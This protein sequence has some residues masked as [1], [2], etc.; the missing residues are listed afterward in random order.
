MTR[1]T[2]RSSTKKS[3]STCNK[4]KHTRNTHLGENHHQKIGKTVAKWKTRKN[5][6]KTRA[7]IL[8]RYFHEEKDKTP[9]NNKQT[10]VKQNKNGAVFA[11]KE[12]MKKRTHSLLE[13]EQFTFKA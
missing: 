2:L 9:K 5:S 13:E 3:T 1:H 7:K 11:P 8:I 4:D 6:L 10:F 12:K